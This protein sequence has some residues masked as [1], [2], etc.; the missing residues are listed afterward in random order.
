F[1]NTFLIFS[2]SGQ[3]RYV[4]FSPF[5]LTPRNLRQSA[6]QLSVVLRKGANTMLSARRWQVFSGKFR[7]HGE[8]ASRRTIEH[9]TSGLTSFR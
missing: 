9:Q 6:L 4:L 7:R 1:I 8:S 5:Q 3:I 2:C